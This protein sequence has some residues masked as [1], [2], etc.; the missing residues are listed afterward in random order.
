LTFA[1]KFHRLKALLAST[2][3]FARGDRLRA[4][5]RRRDNLKGDRFR[6]RQAQCAGEGRQ[7]FFGQSRSQAHVDPQM[8]SCGITPARRAGESGAVPATITPLEA[9]K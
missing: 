6:F 3:P 7:R 4:T 5:F 2:R 9:A 8:R 1:E